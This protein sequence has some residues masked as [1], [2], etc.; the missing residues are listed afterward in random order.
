MPV[1][2]SG[3]PHRIF[4]RVAAIRLVMKEKRPT[5]AGGT[6]SSGLRSAQGRTPGTRRG[7]RPAV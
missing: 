1:R 4:D 3:F 2:V 7:S 6:G 5:G